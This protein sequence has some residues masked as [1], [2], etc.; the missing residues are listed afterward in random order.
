MMCVVCTC[1]VFKI[2]LGMFTCSIVT[3]CPF[4]FEHT[5]ETRIIIHGCFDR[6]FFFF[7]FFSFSPPSFSPTNR[8]DSSIVEK[9]TPT[10]KENTEKKKP[11]PTL[12]RRERTAQSTPV[13]PC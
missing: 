12:R 3:T 7:F 9:N 5:M 4:H 1:F 13:C 6:A 11:L 8:C 2:V 10:E